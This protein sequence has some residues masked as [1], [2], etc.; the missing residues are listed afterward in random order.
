MAKD[1][2][3]RY[4]TM[5]EFEAELLPFDPEGE[6][7]NE[8]IRIMPPVSGPRSALVASAKTA[9]RTSM[10]RGSR[11]AMG[12]EARDVELSRPMITLLGRSEESEFSEGFSRSSVR[13]FEWRAG[14]APTQT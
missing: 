5:A 1:A 2:D 13:S 11:T 8:S 4:Q 7:S 9:Q 6:S 10:N 12:R 3:D 14:A